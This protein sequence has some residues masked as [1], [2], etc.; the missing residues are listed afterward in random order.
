[1]G[2]KVTKKF[3]LI[4]VFV[5]IGLSLFISAQVIDTQVIDL[6]EKV[7][8]FFIE[9]TKGN[10]IGQTTQDIFGT[11][12]AVSSGGEDIQSQ[13]GTLIFLESAEIISPLN[14]FA[15]LTPR[16]LLPEDVGPRITTIFLPVSMAPLLLP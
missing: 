6:S 13:G 2:E 1:M 14:F 16:L 10:I 9:A 8:D 3:V 4:F 11:N 15:I 7:R 12:S 5:V